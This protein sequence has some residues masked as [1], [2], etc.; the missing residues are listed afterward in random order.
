MENSAVCAD[1]GDINVIFYQVVRKSH[2]MLT[3][4]GAASF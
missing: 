3:P 4:A 1:Q 2:I